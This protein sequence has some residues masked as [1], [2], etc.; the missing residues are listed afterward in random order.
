[1]IRLGLIVAPGPARKIANKIKDELAEDLAAHLPMNDEWEIDIIVDPLT[2][3]TEFSEKIYDKADEYLSENEWDFIIS[4]TDL[5]LFYKDKVVAIDIDT[6][7]GVSMISIPA[8]GWRPLSKRIK[9]AIINV[10]SIINKNNNNDKNIEEESRAL[11]SLFPFSKLQYTK[12]FFEDSDTQRLFFH[13]NSKISGTF[14][15]ISGMT[16]AN[17]PYNMMQSLSGVTAI[18]FATGAFGIIFSTM[19][20]LSYLFP[21]WRLVAI[22]ILSILGMLFWIIVSHDLWENVKEGESRRMTFLYNST[23]ILTLFISLLFYY[24]LLYLLFLAAGVML[25]PPDYIATSIEVDNIG[26]KFYLELAWFAASLTTVAGA[27][28]AGFQDKE[29]IRESTYGYRQ[30]FRYEESRE[31][32]SS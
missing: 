19:W 18:A 14:R 10:L 17:N 9:T 24:L 11:N 30:R 16:F 6:S 3:E 15:L 12:D 2:G 26:V 22:S 25:L 28:G 4:I 5:P 29:V 23:T 8:F 7:D 20:N 21:T 1:M 32:D 13:M 31:E 27:I